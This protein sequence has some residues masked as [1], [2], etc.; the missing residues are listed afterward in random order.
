ME[1]KHYKYIWYQFSNIWYRK[2]FGDPIFYGLSNKELALC[3]L[4]TYDRYMED[5]ERKGITCYSTTAIGDTMMIYLYK[6]IDFFKKLLA[7]ASMKKQGFVVI[8]EA[9]LIEEIQ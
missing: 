2:A 5:C 1:Q 4:Q 6:D 3:A 8:D 7:V 9:G